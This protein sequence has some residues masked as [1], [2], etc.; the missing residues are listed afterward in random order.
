MKLSML[1]SN[2]LATFV[3]YV[4]FSFRLQLLF[5]F[6]FVEVTCLLAIARNNEKIDRAA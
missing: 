3:H 6:M 4:K 1:V 2:R 5:L